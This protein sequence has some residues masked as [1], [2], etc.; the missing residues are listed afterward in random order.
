MDK[1]SKNIIPNITL[2]LPLSFA[3][4][5]ENPNNPF[6]P[7]FNWTT[8]L[9]PFQTGFGISTYLQIPQNSKENNISNIKNEI[10]KWSFQ[11]NKEYTNKIDLAVKR[12]ITA[13][14]QRTDPADSLI[15]AVMV[16]ENILGPAT[17]VSFR[18][19]ASMAKM[20]ESQSEKREETRKLLR[21]I[22]DTRSKVVHGSIR[23]EAEIKEY[24]NMAIG[25]AIKLLKIS[26]EKGKDWLEKDGE[27]RSNKILMDI[28]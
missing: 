18:I 5:S 6:V 2:K 15:D 17:E 4:A 13:V 22:Y 27:Y 14:T 19:T 21:K 12:I 20:L 16:W 28:N 7:I 24:V 23:D 25:Y 9:L 10:E 26:F 8:Y 11:I 1:F 3:F